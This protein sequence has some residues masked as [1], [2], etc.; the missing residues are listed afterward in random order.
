MSDLPTLFTGGDE[1]EV[2]PTE[3]G[4]FAVTR[5]GAEMMGTGRVTE[6]VPA[7]RLDAA[8][9]ALRVANDEIARLRKA[10]CSD[11]ASGLPIH[12]DPDGTPYHLF[13]GHLRNDCPAAALAAP[14]ES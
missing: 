13:R 11:C 14:K 6:Y 1:G 10:V 9:E 4:M 3:W 5:D 7:S 12:R 2:G 8:N